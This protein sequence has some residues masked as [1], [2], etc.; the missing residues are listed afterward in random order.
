MASTKPG[1]RTTEF[2]IT[3]AAAVIP[4]LSAAFLDA[5]TIERVVVAIGPIVAAF[6]YSLSRGMAKGGA[7]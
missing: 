4:P 5:D 1:V 3:I 7:A 6:G 2:W